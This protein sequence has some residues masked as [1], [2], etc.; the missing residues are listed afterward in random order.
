M[1]RLYWTS[2]DASGNAVSGLTVTVHD[3]TSDA[4]LATMTDVGDGSYY[5]DALTTTA[6]VKVKENGTTKLSNYR[7]VGDDLVLSAA[8]SAYL[9]S[10]SGASLVGVYDA[11]TKW[12]GNTLQ[13]LLDDEIPSLAD[14]ASVDVNLGASLIGVRDAGGYYAQANVE[15]ILQEIGPRLAL[16]SGLTST[17][18]ELNKLDGTS[19]DVSAVNLNALVAGETTLLHMHD[20]Q[21]W[22]GK[23]IGNYNN[24]DETP[25]PIDFTVFSYNGSGAGPRGNIIL[26]VYDPDGSGRVV[27]RRGDDSEVQTDYDV[28]TSYRF[29][30]FN[31]TSQPMFSGVTTLTSALLKLA[32]E[33]RSVQTTVG[34]NYTVID[35]GGA[36]AAATDGAS[37]GDPR[38][39]DLYYEKGS[40]YVKKRRWAFMQY[41]GQRTVELDAYF[42]GD[43]AGVAYVKLV[44]GSVESEYKII[45]TAYTRNTI[46]VLLDSIAVDVPT[47]RDIE[48]QI[49]G[50]GAGN[51]GKMA[52]WFQLRATS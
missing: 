45:P 42:K 39:T 41:P 52:A 2:Q 9:T 47:E 49:K 26:D 31:L 8:L 15:A 11:A 27:V 18:T 25:G 37:A 32:N 14:L 24:P 20:Y 17:A 46:S 28:I 40:T 50:D 19:G 12:T 35:S 6:L 22:A 7:H 23:S 29:G 44:V 21:S 51:G 5:T 33:L 3:N 13:D 43:S 38:A 36:T 48:I 34:I 10:G 1:S 30:D 16:L 4:L